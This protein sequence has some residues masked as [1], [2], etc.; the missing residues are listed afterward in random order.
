MLDRMDEALEFGLPGV[1]ERQRLLALY[2]DK[3]IA[4]VL[5]GGGEEGAEGGG[6][7][8]GCV[9]G[10]QAGGPHGFPGSGE[11]NGQR[12]GGEAGTKEVGAGLYHGNERPAL[13]PMAH[14]C[15]QFSSR[16]PWL[17]PY[18][19]LQAGTD[20]GGAGAG[21][22][23][24]PLSRL[25]WVL[26]GRKSSADAI[27]IEPSINEALLAATA[28]ATEGFSGE[29]QTHI[30]VSLSLSHTHTHIQILLIIPCAVL[31]T[32]EPRA[33]SPGL[34][35]LGATTLVPPHASSLHPLHPLRP[36]L[37]LTPPLLPSLLPLLLRLLL[38][39]H[40]Q[41]VSWPS[42][43]RRCRRPCTARPRPC[44]R[45]RSGRA[46]CSAS[47]TSTRSAAPSAWGTTAPATRRRSRAAASSSRGRRRVEVAGE[48]PPGLEQR[49]HWV[50]AG[51]PG[52][53]RS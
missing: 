28:K 48:R 10:N 25:S 17:P 40:P 11:L 29:S 27:E 13:V 12:R 6:G 42:C 18:L 7:I 51:A 32:Y 37:L 31:S 21:K 33:L 9:K 3:Y 8:L 46:C 43:W 34:P 39:P 49:P 45:P 47:C 15:L 1:A 30:S 26:K 38:L 20:E 36:D 50:R 23:G 4:K 19:S 24:G 16:P 2:L 5:Q 22:S 35:I 52:T 41:P 53:L 14:I 44:S